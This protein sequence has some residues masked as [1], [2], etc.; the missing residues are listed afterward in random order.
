MANLLNTSSII[1]CPHGGKVSAVTTNTRAKASGA[2][3][4]RA[5]DTFLVA[6]CTFAMGTTPHPCVRVQ[7]VQSAQKSKAVGTF[8]LTQ[9]SVGQCIAGDGAVQGVALITSTQPRVSG[10]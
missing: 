6:G 1:Q 4:L 5:S 2:Y 3:L 10:Q 8:T 7:W 9:E